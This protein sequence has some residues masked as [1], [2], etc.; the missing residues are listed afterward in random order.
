MT[1]GTL[2]DRA[3]SGHTAHEF[4]HSGDAFLNAARQ[5]CALPVGHEFPGTI[6]LLLLQAIELH[7]KALLIDLGCSER[8]LW[9]VGH[10]YRRIL[11][12]CR[13]K[14]VEVDGRLLCSLLELG[15]PKF[16]LHS[17]SPH[18]ISG[19]QPSGLDEHIEDICTRSREAAAAALRARGNPIGLL[20]GTEPDECGWPTGNLD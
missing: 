12:L 19:V 13:A 11:K 9:H 10:S 8:Q 3:H 2:L 18:Q 17:M 7:W 6:R 20:P 1:L 16:Q 14:G 4:F 15:H 5:L